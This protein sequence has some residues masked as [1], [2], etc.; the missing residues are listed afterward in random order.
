MIFS[1]NFTEPDEN[2]DHPDPP[3]E[4][5]GSGAMVPR[6]QLLE[7]LRPRAFGIAYG[8][9]GSLTEAEDVVQQALLRVHEALD[10]GEQV[11][12]PV[13]YAATVT[14]RL[15]IDE[16]RSARARRERYVG[17][18]LPEP[19][20][21]RPADDAS[22][23][24]EMSNFLSVALLVLLES[25]SSEQRAASDSRR[26]EPG[27]GDA[28][29]IERPLNATG[30]AECQAVGRDIGGNEAGGTDHRV[31]ANSDAR[32]D[33]GA[34]SEPDAILNDNWPGMRTIGRLFRLAHIER[35]DTLCRVDRVRN[36]EELNAGSDEDVRA[37]A[38]GCGI[39]EHA[40]HVDEGVIADRDM[41]AVVTEKRRLDP[42]AIADVIQELDEGA[43][44]RSGVGGG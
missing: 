1:T 39:Q 15:A 32:Q 34:G 35:D 24:A 4:P 28:V 9:L 27:R 19:L 10:K 13:A 31:R 7:E 2:P 42:D 25:L 17:D 38:N 40:V 43:V 30:L 22:R 23:W 14:S 12:S 8:M 36:R 44:A 29:V 20:V 6:D 18:R 26:R 41:L 33:D 37:N 3:P 11:E 21:T 16:L 5:R